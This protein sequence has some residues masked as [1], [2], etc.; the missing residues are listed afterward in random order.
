[1]STSTSS[2]ATVPVEQAGERRSARVESLRALAALAV[3]V[4]HAF[5]LSFGNEGG[6]FDGTK[7][8][9]LVGGGLGV[10]LFFTLSGY[11]LFLPFLKAQL[12]LRGRVQLADYARNRILRILPL[13]VVVIT[14]LSV[15]RPFEGQVSDWWRFMLFIQN[16]S[17]ESITL[18]D[19]PVWSL[20]VE[21]HF[22]IVLPLFAF[23]LALVARRSLVVTSLIL[24]ALA[25]V[26]YK[27]REHGVFE[28]DQ[29]GVLYGLYSLPG[30]MYLFISGMLL[31]V[32]KVWCDRARPGWMD[33]PVIGWSVVWFAVGV[34]L[35]AYMATK[36]QLV[37]TQ[38]LPFA[39]FLVVASAVLPLRSGLQNAV[40]EWRPLALVGVASYSLYLVHV[41][42][43]QVITGTHVRG[44]DGALVT[45][46]DGMDFKVT[47]LLAIVVVAPVTAASYLGIERPFLRLRKRW[48]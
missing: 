25:G 22:Y 3:F 34:G 48:V 10:F 12:G 14:V 33:L 36:N 26:S 27:V 11:L 13:Y 4:G 18:P 40:L 20:Q 41:P 2:E 35:Y 32:A 47:L 1:M 17:G 45:F 44:V 7:N 29:L 42:I 39:G 23:L 31:A 43:I 37:Q 9:L 38:L 46:G 16:Y 8:K 15:I 19:S 6:V 30:L 21:M 24:L 28:H 5:A